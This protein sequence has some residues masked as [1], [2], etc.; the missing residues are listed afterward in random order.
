M[1]SLANAFADE[2][3]AEFVERIRRFLQIKA[4]EPVVFTA[5]PKIDG[6]VAEPALRRGPARQR[7]DAGRWRNRRGCDGQCPH[8]RRH[9]PETGGK[10]LPDILEVRGE[11]YLSH[12]DFAAINERQAA[13][14]K[15]IF[16]NPRNAAAGSLRQLDSRITA[17]RPLHFFAYG[18]GEISAHAGDDAIGHDRCVRKRLVSRPIR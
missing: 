13:A 1:L 16:A 17:S 14:G 7:G 15:Q 12:A 8:C 6:L 5:E 4:D 18:W 11:V 3:V 9:S 10:D 2:E